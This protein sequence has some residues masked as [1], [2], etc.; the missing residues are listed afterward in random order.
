MGVFSKNIQPTQEVKRNTVDLSRQNNLTM[1]FGGLYPFICEEVLPGDSW[2]IDAAAGLRFLPTFFP[3]QNK[4]KVKMDFFFCRN[5]N[6]WKDWTNY[7]FRTGMPSAFP[8]L[9]S[10]EAIEQ[11]KTG[12][13]GDYL[14]LPSTIVQPSA[15]YFKTSV[16]TTKKFDNPVDST[17]RINDFQLAI[18]KC[19]PATGNIY[20]NSD[21]VV[22]PNGQFAVAGSTTKVGSIQAPVYFRTAQLSTTIDTIPVPLIDSTTETV[23]LEYNGQTYQW[24]P[25]PTTDTTSIPDMNSVYVMVNQTQFDSATNKGRFAGVP[26][27]Y[28]HYYH[29]ID[30]AV[31]PDTYVPRVINRDGTLYILALALQSANDIAN[32]N[33]FLVCITD[34]DKTT[35]NSILIPTLDSFENAG[36]NPQ[37]VTLN[38][39]SPQAPLGASIDVLLPHYTKEATTFAN[40]VVEATSVLEKI[41][42][43]ISALPFRA[44]EQI[45]NA[46]YRDDR[47]N[48]LIIDGVVDPNRFLPTIEGGVDY[49]KY[50]LHY[51]NY[52]QDFLTTALPSPQFGNAPL[53]GITSTGVATFAD[54]DGNT[55]SSK[56][57]LDDDGKVVSFSTTSNTGV[58][59]SLI[60]LASSGISINDLRGVNSLQRWLEANMRRGLRYRDQLMSHFGVEPNYD[61]LDMPEFIGSVVVPVQVDQINQTSSSTSTDPLGSY[62]GQLSAAGSG[63]SLQKYCDENGYI[64]GIVSVVPTPMYS[65]LC[66]KHFLKT[67]E[68]LDYYSPEFAYLGYQPIKYNQVCP[69]Q[70]TFNNV[71]LNTTFGYQRPWYE[72]L[73]SVDEIHGQFRTSLSSYVLSR[74]YQ[75]VPSLNEDFLTVKPSDFNDVF[76]VNDDS[77]GNPLDTILGQIHLDI[78]VKR[79]IPL[80]GE[81]KLE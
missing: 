28:C 57:N 12:S 69:L 66:P 38:L 39:T 21:M 10:T 33:R 71:D 40:S 58:N 47:N 75:T 26:T 60:E 30:E 8:T 76:S 59:S 49:T 1:K 81:P 65:Q 3:L 64:I 77:S 2:K 5:R 53:V 50:R 15:T 29:V 19:P 17:G 78:S 6:L 42:Y 79:A 51:R 13:L 37:T 9:S 62:A 72:Y 25:V 45:Y 46:F 27:Y 74:V 11:S 48:P 16:Y 44:Y 34:F 7:Q 54:A 4:M 43:E 32:T 70:A 31:G 55:Y 20:S 80:F 36:T 52:E 35:G 23:P 67:H 41:P 68:N 24:I 22:V 73:S 61:V 14:G 56:L 18:A 63:D